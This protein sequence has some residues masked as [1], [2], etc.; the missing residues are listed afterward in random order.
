MCSS[1]LPTSLHRCRVQRSDAIM[2]QILYLCC[3]LCSQ[4]S[5]PARAES[6]IFHEIQSGAPWSPGAVGRNIRRR[7]LTA[8]ASISSFM[9]GPHGNGDSNSN[10][11]DGRTVPMRYPT[12]KGELTALSATAHRG[13]RP[14]TITSRTGCPNVCADTSLLESYGSHSPIG[15]DG[16]GSLR[17]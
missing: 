13:Q 16:A 17:T 10:E 5:H 6:P 2:R 1:D 4:D 11:T 12:R 7:H 3:S 15:I 8:I 14:R 9:G